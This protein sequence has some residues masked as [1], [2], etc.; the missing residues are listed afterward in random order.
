MVL[1]FQRELATKKQGSLNPQ[2]QA[3][4]NPRDPMPNSDAKPGITFTLLH[5]H[6]NARI[7]SL[8]PTRCTGVERSERSQ[9]DGR[10]ERSALDWAPSP[11]RPPMLQ[12]RQVW[13]KMS[14]P[15]L[16]LPYEHRL[17]SAN[18]FVCVSTRQHPCRMVPI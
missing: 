12:L 4:R 18:A 8:R 16:S 3:W 2:M 11:L 7:H 9:N 1:T 15:C 17:I 10:A 14:R 5:R 13:S 6:L